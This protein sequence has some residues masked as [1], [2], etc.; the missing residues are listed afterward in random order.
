MRGPLC[1]GAS[2]TLM[3]LVTLMTL[4]RRDSVCMGFNL[5]LG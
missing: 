2:M 1:L 4:C 5:A 3:T